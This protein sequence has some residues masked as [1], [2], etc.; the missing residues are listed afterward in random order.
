MKCEKMESFPNGIFIK[1]LFQ[2]LPKREFYHL[3][4]IKVLFVPNFVLFFV[5]KIFEK[6]LGIF[7]ETISGV[8]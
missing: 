8:Y 5:V 7:C 6:T 1:T 2:D 3:R 4:N